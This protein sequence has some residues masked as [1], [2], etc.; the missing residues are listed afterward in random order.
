MITRALNFIMKNRTN[1]L[2]VMILCSTLIM[3]NWLAVTIISLVTLQKGEIEGGNLLGCMAFIGILSYFVNASYFILD[4][5]IFMAIPVWVFSIVLKKTSSWS[6]VLEAL[7]FVGILGVIIMYSFFSDWVYGAIEAFQAF[8]LE[9]SMKVGSTNP[10]AFFL[11]IS[12]ILNSFFIGIMILIML[13]QILSTLMLGRV[14]Q[15]RLYNKGGFKKEFNSLTIGW[16]ANAF[17]LVA[18]IGTLLDLSL[19]KAFL[20]IVFLPFIIVG[21]SVIHYFADK[22]KNRK[23]ILGFFYFSFMLYSPAIILLLVVTAILEK[24]FNF[25]ALGHS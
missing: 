5:V 4:S 9:V 20:P 2:L 13:L 21:V 22:R 17:L 15:A 8:V 3:F 18:L 10:S 14:C 16:M 11:K 23:I 19:T 24:Y 6:V 1:A 7:V 25:R 12:S